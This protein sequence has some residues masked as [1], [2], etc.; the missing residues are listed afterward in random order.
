MYSILAKVTECTIVYNLYY[1]FHTFWISIQLDPIIFWKSTIKFILIF[2]IVFTICLFHIFRR[3]SLI[4]HLRQHRQLLLLEMK[5]KRE[6]KRKEKML[7]KL[8]KNRVREEEREK[9]RQEKEKRKVYFISSFKPSLNIL[10][11]CI[12]NI[13]EHCHPSCGTNKSVWKLL[14]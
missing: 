14:T 4:K 5:V 3:L 10:P 7:Q 12:S 9:L 6:E 13:C 8:K 11:I 2:I 1:L